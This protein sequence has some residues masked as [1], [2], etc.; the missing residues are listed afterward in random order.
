MEEIIRKADSGKTHM[1]KYKVL[2]VV[3]D[4]PIGGLETTLYQIVTHLDPQKYDVRTCCLEEGGPVAEELIS[5]GCPVDTLGLNNYYNPRQILSFKK[6]L[7][8][9]TP[10]I[11]HTHGEFAST[12]ARLTALLNGT[13]VI[14]RHIQT[15]ANLKFRH[16]I[17]DGVLTRLTGGAIAVSEDCASHHIR[18][19]LIPH[20]KMMI[21]PNGVDPELFDSALF[22]SQILGPL[23]IGDRHILIGC[24]G[25]LSPIKGHIFMIRAMPG[26]LQKFPHARLL[27]IGDGPEKARLL[28]EATRLS[29]SE[30]II[31]TG[32]RRD[33]PAI[34]KA[35]QVF[36]LPSTDVEG[37]PLSIVEAMCAGVPVVASEVGGVSEIVKHGETGLLVPPKDS[38]WLSSAILQV[39]EHPDLA[40]RLSHSALILSR[41]HYSIQVL[42]KRLEK[43]YDDLL[44]RKSANLSMHSAMAL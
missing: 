17:Y 42:I 8:K 27:I 43:I 30:K 10:D 18:K 24:V 3:E 37:L 22:P 13:P 38:S 40:E 7:Q 5:R 44:S 20:E 25:R 31:L 36:V 19:C 9:H 15:K 6:Y 16:R 4:L 21:L 29:I 26:I 34:L 33:V 2:Q 35:L 28:Q 39:L 32:L 23:G 11:V 41:N 12:F 14:L 1:R